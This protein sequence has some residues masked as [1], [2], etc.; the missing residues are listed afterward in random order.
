MQKVIIL[1]F[2]SQYTFL[3]ARRV[4]EIGIYS[5]IVKGT[6]KLEKLKEHNPQAIIISGGPASVYKD[7]PLPDKRIFD[8]NIPVLGICYGLQAITI[9]FN[10]KVGPSFEREYGPRK[11]YPAEDR[12]FNSLNDSIDVWM[13]HGDEIK[14]L[15]EGF[16]SIGR[17]DSVK[18]AAIKKQ[19]IYGVQFHPEVYHTPYGVKVLKNFLLEIAGLKREWRLDNFVKKEINEIRG[20]TESAKVIIGVSGG[21]DSS[22]AAVLIHKAIGESLLPIFVDTGLLRKNEVEEVKNTLSPLIPN[23]KIID[24]KHIFL[25]ALKGVINPEEK[26]KVIGHLFI[27]IFEKEAK[28]WGAKFLAQGTLYPDVIESGVSIGN[29][30]KIKSHHNVGGLPEKM[31]LRLLEPL[32]YL[33]KDEVRKIGKILGIADIYLKRHPFPGPG[34]AVRIIGEITEER[35]SILKEADAIFIEELRKR[36]WYDKIWQAFVVLLPIK[37]VG[38]KGDERSYEY[39]VVLRAVESVDGM[40]ADWIKLPHKLL[41]DISRRIAGEVKGVNRVVYDITSKPPSTIEWE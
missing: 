9:L 24:A 34:L 14:V 40:T 39:P 13:S 19:N 31:Q 32:R 8:M 18:Y 17:T 27:K 2:G 12:L 41:Q 4:R 11:F 15:P 26:R 37:N 35:L 16:E 33:F 1:D 29:S 10:G 3:I 38:V 21:V 22:V 25:K 30:A 7:G 20:V 36:G 28:E 6:I 23:L 5:E